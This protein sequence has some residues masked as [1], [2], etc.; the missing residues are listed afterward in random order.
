MPA[1][2]WQDLFFWY[3]GMILWIVIFAVWFSSAFLSI[4]F[5]HTLT[6]MWRARTPPPPPPWLDLPVP[7]E[8]V[9]ELLFQVRL[10]GKMMD[11]GHGKN[12]MRAIW[13]TKDYKR[14]SDIRALLGDPQPVG[15]FLKKLANNWPTLS[16]EADEY[17]GPHPNG[18]PEDRAS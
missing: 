5:R 15:V 14:Q 18:R 6:R 7:P 13:L 16:A 10:G 4:K 3:S 1:W 11:N 12:E 2:H 9:M 8:G 17:K